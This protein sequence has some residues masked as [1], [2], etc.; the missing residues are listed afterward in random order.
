MPNSVTWNIT[1]G[2]GSIDAN[3]LYT[4]PVASISSQ[5]VI[6]QAAS[7]LPGNQCA[8]TVTLTVTPAQVAPQ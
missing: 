2:P 1:S 6:I 8:A 7:S 5:W 3:G 4:A